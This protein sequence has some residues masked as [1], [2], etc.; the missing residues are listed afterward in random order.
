LRRR[1]NTWLTIP[2]AVAAVGALYLW[3]RG[4]D[5]DAPDIP[6][7]IAA[8]SLSI[9]TAF[10]R[11][12]HAAIDPQAIR[13]T[14]VEELPNRSFIVYLEVPD[15]GA[16]RMAAVY[17]LCLSPGTLGNAGGFITG[18]ADPELIAQREAARVVTCGY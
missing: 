11:G 5:G 12:V 18:P 10:V 8:A 14:S 2:L 1:P 4:S 15:A 17:G 16:V 3:P 6:P 9:K 7:A 13:I